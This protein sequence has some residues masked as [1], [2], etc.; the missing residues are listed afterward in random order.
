L[1]F[2]AA[3]A[4]LAAAASA[5]SPGRS[6]WEG[7]YTSEQA[8]RGGA[9]YNEHCVVCH[10]AQLEGVDAG[11]SLA[12]G[13]FMSAWNTIDLG[14]MQERIRVTM[15]LSAPGS[16]SS[17]EATDILAFILEANEFPTGELELHRR[18]AAQAQIV[19]EARPP[20]E[21]ASASE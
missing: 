10:G 6:A 8:A 11:P 3:A 21:L 14:T 19:F 20:E 17:Q 4:C 5:Q 12:G 18:K 13:R 9:L 1:A 2:A 16:L 15:P 7:V